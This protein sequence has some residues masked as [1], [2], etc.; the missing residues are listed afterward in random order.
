PTDSGTSGAVLGLL[1]NGKLDPT[2]GDGGLA[3]TNVGAGNAYT[4]GM[5]LLPDDRIIALTSFEDGD[6]ALVGLT[7]DG[8][9][10]HRFGN[11]GYLGIDEDGRP[12]GLD[13]TLQ[14]DGTI[15]VVTSNDE[16]I[17]FAR[18]TPGGLYDPA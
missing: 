8:K 7:K 16:G 3:D 18:V 1:P 11:D 10:D 15:L 12:Y 9:L 5:V 2:F 4:V 6:S 17:G 13:M 14:P